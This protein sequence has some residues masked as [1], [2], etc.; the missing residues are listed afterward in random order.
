VTDNADPIRIV[1]R[2]EVHRGWMT[3]TRYTLDFR[4]RNGRNERVVREVEH[5][6]DSAAVLPL[7]PERECVLL[8]RQFRLAAH[9]NG[10]DGRLIEACA[11]IIDEG[12]TPEAAAQREAWEE[13]GFAVRDLAVVTSTFVSPGASMERATLF[14]ARYS[15]A[16]RISEGGGVDAGEEIEVV[17]MPLSEAAA[18]IGHGRIVDAKTIILIQAALLRIHQR[19]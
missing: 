8:S 1:R 6:G 2:E 3:L 9:L 11:G 10:H 15:P 14:A 12:E 16:D 18:A 5:H 17:E 13:L 7:D 19:P 4:R